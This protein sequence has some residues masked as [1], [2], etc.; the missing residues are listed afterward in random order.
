ML[1][2]FE[3]VKPIKIRHPRTLLGYRLWVAKSM[4]WKKFTSHSVTKW[5]LVRIFES[6]QEMT[7]GDSIHEGNANDTFQQGN[8]PFRQALHVLQQFSTLYSRDVLP[9]T[10]TISFSSTGFCKT[11]LEEQCFMGQMHWAGCIVSEKWDFCLEA[12]LLPLSGNELE[13]PCFVS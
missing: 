1:N 11:D 7:A 12:L 8:L 6:Q 4:G 2:V 10:L 5:W 3:H 13:N 9:G